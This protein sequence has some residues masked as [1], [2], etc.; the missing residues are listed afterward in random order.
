MGHPVT[1]PMRMI[2]TENLSENMNISQSIPDQIFDKRSL[3]KQKFGSI[4]ENQQSIK[5]RSWAPWALWA[6]VP[7]GSRMLV[8]RRMTAWLRQW[9]WS[10]S[11]AITMLA[12]TGRRQTSALAP[13]LRP[14]EP[15]QRCFP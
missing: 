12:G 11:V 13:M 8:G 1:K 6:H 4:S 3:R 14:V 10:S 2:E 7:S 9:R 5:L 15:Q